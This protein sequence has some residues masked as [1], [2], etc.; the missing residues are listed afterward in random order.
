[1]LILTACGQSQREGDRMNTK[2]YFPEQI[3]DWVRADTIGSYDRESIFGY[4]DGAGE[5][6]NSYRFSAVLTAAYVGPGDTTINVELFDMGTPAD[7]YGVFSYAREDEQS[8]IGGGYEARGGV[9]CFWQDRYYICLAAE[10]SGPG[11][12]ETVKRL[13]EQFSALLPEAVPPPRLLDLL[14]ARGRVAYSE[15]YFHLH[16]SLNYHYYYARE[17][18]L[19]LSDRTDAVLARYT[20]GSSILCIVEYPDAEI[21]AEAHEALKV[22]YPDKSD[23]F[24]A[25]DTAPSRFPWWVQDGNILAVVFNASDRKTAYDL[26]DRVMA[27]I[28]MYLAE[29]KPR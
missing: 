1:M 10:Q 25:V 15:R 16:Q 11:I 24:D 8:G 23:D 20:P 26:L 12:P 5:V 13:A 14:P 7:A 18:V 21:A 4:I 6:Y 17:N 29:E 3:G 28:G 22:Y 2:D 9:L 19:G 27:H